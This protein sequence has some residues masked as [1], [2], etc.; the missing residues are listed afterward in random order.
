MFDEKMRVTVFHFNSYL[1]FQKSGVQNCFLTAFTAS[2]VASVLYM[3]C[4][5]HIGA[6]LHNFVVR[7][8]G[9]FFLLRM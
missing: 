8:M 4:G 9:F 2:R 3:K 7:K 6:T 5:F 1:Y